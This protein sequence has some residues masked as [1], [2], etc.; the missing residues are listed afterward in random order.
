MLTINKLIS[1]S[2]VD[3]A[4]EEL[5]KY[6]R[7]MMPEGGDVKISYDPEA[8]DGF[9]LGLMQDLR[10]DISDAEDPELDDILYINCDTRGGIIAGD[11]PRS[12]LLAVYEYLRQNGCRWLMP[13]VDGEYI[14]MKDIEPVKYRHAPSCR[15]RGWCN[16]GSESQQSMIDAIE[17]IPKLGMNVFMLE[18]RI[19]TSYYRRYYDHIHNEKNRPKET[20]THSTI[21]QWKRACE[22]EIAK[23]G[24]QF[25]DIGHGW[26]T[27]AFGIDSSLR[28]TDG[29]VDASI[30]PEARQYLALF[31]GRRGLRNNT[32]N[33]TQFCMGNEEARKKVAEYVAS[34]AENHSNSTYLHVWLGDSFNRHCEC[35]LCI[36]ESPSDLYMKL[37]NEI[38]EELTKRNLKTRIVF[39]AY[40]DTIWPPERERINNPDRFTLLLAPVQ[41]K[42]TETYPKVKKGFIP[43]PYK[44]NDNKAAV[45]LE[46]TF[47][48][49]DEWKKVWPGSNFSYE[50]HFWRHQY[51]DLGGFALS[52]RINED[53]KFYKENDVNGIIEDG[54]QR[55]FFPTG[56]PFYTYARTLFDTSLS[57]EE[58]ADDYFKFAFGKGAAEFRNYLRELGDAFDF[59]YM[60]GQLSSNPNVSAFY[61]PE[62]AKS[63]A[64]VK[65]ITTRGRE[66]IKKYYNSDHRVQTVSVRLLEMHADYADMLSEALY[67]KALGDD[68]KS[69]ALFAAFKDEIGK[70]EIEF[71]GYYDHGLVF[72]SL[73]SIFNRRSNTEP[74]TELEN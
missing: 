1:S 19:P 28:A 45:D 47:A 74:I 59:R 62:H 26:G 70:R 15:Y 43:V 5:K 13:G 2:V 49:F 27:D 61:N 52:E 40:L 30:S 7:M 25:H 9:R 55:S 42:Y 34:Y 73:P 60:E 11:N 8:K 65:E 14:P 12:V 16:E 69:D 6:L 41:R 57:V 38:D 39:I 21:L 31:E 54:S 56:L 66:L 71:E 20:V 46:E 64:R 50:Y 29:E 48:Y 35:D 3:Y 10:L 72:Y 32:P 51:Y 53:I 67:A 44:R 18:F 22:C 17:F 23:R 36:N 58:I 37:C 68:E 63:L 4:A 33:Y 24:L